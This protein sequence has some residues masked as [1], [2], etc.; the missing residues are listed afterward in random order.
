[1]FIL[2]KINLNNILT[3]VVLLKYCR[4]TFYLNV[5]IILIM[6]T[7]SN[8]FFQKYFRKASNN[9]FLKGTL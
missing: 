1:M 2:I 9:L 7:V 6:K 5:L 4:K 8:I 3:N